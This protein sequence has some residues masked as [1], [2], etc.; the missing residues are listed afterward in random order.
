MSDA[1]RELARH[2]IAASPFA[3]ALGVVLE[4]LE[5]ERARLALPFLER[6]ANPGAALHG[7]VAASLAVIAAGALAR[8]IQGASAAPWHTAALQV[9]YLSAAIGEPVAARAELLRRGKELC[10]ALVEV[11]TQAGKPVASATA[12]L[13]GR[14]GA[15]PAALAESSASRSAGEPGAFGRA[16]SKLSFIA[17]CGIEVQ[18][19]AAGRSRLA[20]P[21]ARENTDAGGG[22]HEGALLALFDTAGAAA[23]WSEIGPGP[24]KA[25]TPALQ[26]QVLAPPAAEGLVAHGHCRQRD[27]EL[28]F[29]DVEVS[30]AQSRQ[31][32][33]RGALH[34]RIVR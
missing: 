27:Q 29:C 8:A 4:A 19:M 16:L 11:E 25:S 9:S 18:E 26:V 23:A 3:Q 34:Y 10:F 20:L 1:N 31:I 6:N 22:V 30:G 2:W 24:Y 14:A 21:C 17:A 28:F 12:M 5:P 7:G 15:P 33:A 13:R 32:V